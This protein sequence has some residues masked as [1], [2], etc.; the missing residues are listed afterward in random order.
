MNKYKYILIIALFTLLAACSSDTTADEEAKKSEG[1]KDTKGT[2]ELYSLDNDGVDEEAFQKDLGQLQVENPE[3]IITTSVPI[4]E[5]L[6]LLDITPVGV[7]TSTN[8]LPD[9]FADIDQIGSPMEPD[10]EVVTDLEPDLILGAK[11]L[12]DSLETSLAGI[13]LNRAYLPTDSFDDLKRTFKVLG[14]YFDKTD[15]MNTVLEDIL[16]MENELRQQ[17]DGKETPSV[18]I[19]IGASDSFMVMNDES[20]V[21]SLVEKLGAENIATTVLDAKDTYSPISME[22]VVVA[23]PDMIFVLASGDHGASEE[24]FN[25]EVESNEIW[26]SLSAYKEDEIHMLDHETFGVTSIQNIE[27]AMTQIADYFYK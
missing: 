9:E 22:D 26:K 13:D 10:L 27:G 16:Q 23:D 25:Q 1:N 15:E 11:S 5:M 12:E 7:P 19:V 18:L 6:Q 14:T 2:D 17:A 20:Y 3:R 8:P 4:A 21:G 24:M